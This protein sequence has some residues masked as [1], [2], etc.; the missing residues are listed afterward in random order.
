ME[1]TV[2]VNTVKGQEAAHNVAVWHN[3][4]TNTIL[5]S[6]VILGYDPIPSSFIS[7]VVIQVSKT[8]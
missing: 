1:F 4:N 3:V 2:S 8:Q 6:F 7:N 5:F